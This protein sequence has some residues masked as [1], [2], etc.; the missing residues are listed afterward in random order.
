MRVEIASMVDVAKRTLTSEIVNDEKERA[1]DEA[2]GW[3]TIGEGV[4][5]EVVYWKRGAACPSKD[6]C[7]VIGA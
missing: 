7:A 5:G 2:L 3:A 1:D 6:T 4:V